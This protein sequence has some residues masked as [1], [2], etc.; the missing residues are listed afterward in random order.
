MPERTKEELL[1]ADGLKQLQTRHIGFLVKV[2]GRLHCFAKSHTAFFFALEQFDKGAEVVIDIQ[3][4]LTG[5][6]QERRIRLKQ[7]FEYFAEKHRRWQQ[8]Q[9]SLDGKRSF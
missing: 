4:G 2:N 5:E 6:R 7:D 8:E 3:P 9:R 1:A